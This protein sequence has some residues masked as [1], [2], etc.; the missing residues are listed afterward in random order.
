[1]MS[2]TV[3]TGNPTILFKVS[4]NCTLTLPSMINPEVS[5]KLQQWQ[6]WLTAQYND[7][8]VEKK[9][10]FVILVTNFLSLWCT[11]CLPGISKH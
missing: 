2:R 3:D 5:K 1:M 6:A 11:E 10:F 7:D 4:N 9:E 8:H